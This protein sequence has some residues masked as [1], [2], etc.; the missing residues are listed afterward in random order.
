MSIAE[1]RALYQERT[2]SVT[3]SDALQRDIQDLA[4]GAERFARLSV[5]ERV[6]LA[7]T[8][9]DGVMAT[10]D[11]WVEAACRAKGLPAG[12][13]YRAEEIAGGPL[14]TA[15]YL[16]LL[17]HSLRD[18]DRHGGPQLPRKPSEG[19]DGRLR[20]PVMPAKGV[21]D[22]LLFSGFKAHVW[23]QPS[24]TRENLPEHMG[25]AYR[26]APP[27]PG[28]ALVLG[29]GNV[30]SIPPTDAFT[31]LFQEGKTV[32]L[33][34]NPVNEY[35]GPIFERAFSALIAPGYL[36]IVYGGAEVGARAI[37]DAQ[38]DEV[39]ITGSIYSHDAIVW[40]PPGTDRERRKAQHDPVLKKKITSELGN[41]TP[42]IVVPGPYSDAQ[43]KFQAENLAATVTNNAS[44]N[45]VAT[46]MIVT[47]KG[48]RDRERYLDLVEGVFRRLPRR[49]A[50]YPG[51]MDR[52]VKFA[53]HEP[54]R[55][56]PGTLPFIMLRDI[57]PAVHS[58]YCQEESFV[59]VVGET[60][61]EA[62][63]EGEFLRKATEFAN[64]SLWGTLGAGIMIHPAFRKQGDNERLFQQCLAELRYGTIGVNHWPALSYAMMSPPWGGYPGATLEDTKSGIGWVHNTYMLDG[65]EKTVLE[66]PLTIFPKPLWFP[67]HAH[68]EEL[69]RKVA[70]F[71]HAPSPW[72]LPSVLVSA[73][74]G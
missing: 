13:P 60:A 51:A 19:P 16:Q 65:I 49:K 55:G 24:V 25:A 2:Q 61:L 69:S 43:L 67:T 71:Y 12:S 18:I 44:F 48:W 7:Q 58:L 33:K 35:L 50:Y 14:A 59:S 29:A 6:L 47:W 28:V 30:S 27:K 15:R 73:L 11:E 10:A 53:R 56:E 37:E 20:V 42:W 31:K 1:P 45:C 36:R 52:F 32:L 4:K 41:V 21:Y 72:R 68:A 39:H 26:G 17:M 34:M 57:D 70:R 64:E 54:A 74:K 63:D 66:G 22:S 5:R 38:V 40:G 8:C 23:M 62:K 3:S 46:K 9:L